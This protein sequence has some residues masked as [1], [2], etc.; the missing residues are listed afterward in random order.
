MERLLK[1]LKEHKLLSAPAEKY[2][3]L[4]DEQ[5]REHGALFFIEIAGRSYKIMLPSPHHETF[6][7]N[8]SP[9]VQQLLHHKEAMLL[10]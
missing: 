2:T 3:L 8:T 7:R 5:G 4:I 6:L 9:T 1:L 10:K